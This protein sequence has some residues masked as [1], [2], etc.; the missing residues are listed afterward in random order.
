[1]EPGRLGRA[2]S[3]GDRRVP[4]R[5]RHRGK[6]ARGGPI[7][8]DHFLLY[9]NADGHR[10]LH[11]AARRVRRGMGRRDRHGRRGRRRAT[12]AAGPS[13]SR[14]P[15]RRR[16]PGAR[17]SPRPSPTTPSPHRWPRSPGD[18]H[19]GSGPAQRTA[20]QGR[21]L[22]D[23]HASAPT[24]CRSRPASTSTRRPRRLPYLHDLGVDWV[25]LSPLLEAEPGS[26][27]GY[28]V[29]DPRPGRPS[30]GGAEGRPRCRPRPGGSAWAC[31]STSCPT[32]SA[33]RRPSRTPG[34]GTCSAT[35]ASRRTRGVR[36][37]LGLGAAVR[38]PCSVTTTCREGGPEQ[39]PRATTSCATTTPL[40]ARPRHRRRCARPR[41]T[42]ASTTSWSLA[43]RRRRA[44][45]PPLLRGHHAGRDPGRG[46]VGVRRVARARSCRWVPTASSTACAS[47]TRTACSTRAATSTDCRPRPAAPTCSSRRSSSPARSCPVTGRSTARPA[48]RRCA[49]RPG[50]RRPGRQAPL[51][52]L[53]ARL[54]GAPSM[55]RAHPRH[56]ARRRRRIAAGRGPGRIV[57]AASTMPP[58]LHERRCEDAVAELLA[59]FPVYRSYLPAGRGTST[60]PGRRARAPAR[61]GRCV[62]RIAPCSPTRPTRRRC[63]SS[64]P[65]AW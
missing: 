7:T 43:A 15:H 27:H 19:A 35:A 57:R 28:D 12:L 61:S 51:D 25:Y 22:T 62:R 65:P 41:C 34:G 56:Q 21:R 4:Q 33:S 48:T 37:R 49:N 36:H 13:S 31:S 32:T 10:R 24:G 47:T 3:Q 58:T 2:A 8:D 26:D 53:E 1:M 6:D 16:P 38:L 52:A 54:R 9:F 45:L 50:V 40:P 63:G 5:R 30:R 18:G 59:C 17:T 42:T 11:P 60:R 44:E 39:S 14:H 46:P 23:A 64:R 29:V 55:G 20:H